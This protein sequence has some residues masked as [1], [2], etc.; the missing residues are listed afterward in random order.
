MSNYQR[1]LEEVRTY[2]I[3]RVPLI[4]IDTAERARAE[5][6]LRAIAG[7]LSVDISYYTDARQVRSLTRSGA[8]VDVDRDPLP[9]V[10]EEFQKKRRA[11]FALGDCAGQGKTAPIRGSWS[12]SP[13]WR[14][15]R[16]VRS[17]SSR[18]TPSGR[19]SRSLA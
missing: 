12:T 1:T 4:I 3:A 11:T 13:I 15:N 18:R 16:A 14:R 7:E 5:R 6:L 8:R 2:I 19:G 17:S 10:A 9:Y